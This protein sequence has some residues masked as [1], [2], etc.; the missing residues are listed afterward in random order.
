[1]NPSKQSQGQDG[2]TNLPSRVVAGLPGTVRE[3]RGTAS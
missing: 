2:M 3:L 1:M